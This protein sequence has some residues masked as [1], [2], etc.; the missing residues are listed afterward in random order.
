MTTLA[1][2]EILDLDLD[3]TEPE[4]R[5]A[6]RRAARQVHPDRNPGD[7]F[8]A[9]RFR[10]VRAA[11]EAMMRDRLRHA[12]P[13]TAP[14]R[15]ACVPVGPHLVG[16]LSVGA[17]GARRHRWIPLTLWA[18]RRCEPCEG[19]GSFVLERSF[20]FG[21]ERRQSCAH[22]DGNGIVGV[23]RRLHVRFTT[24]RSGVALRLRGKGIAPGGDA[25]VHLT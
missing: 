6:Y 4:I 3:A 2:H 13:P 18:I 12:P 22:C 8:A 20:P 19:E 17:S 15:V 21:L 9:A 11:Y 24:L 16:T 7:P 23:E 1:P 5:L 10:E 14:V 25:Y